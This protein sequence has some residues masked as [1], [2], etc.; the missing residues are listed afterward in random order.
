MARKAARPTPNPE[1][2]APEPHDDAPAAEPAATSP[3]PAEA[4]PESSVRSERITL[5]SKTTSQ[6]MAAHEARFHIFLVDT[7]WNAPVSKAVRH[8]LPLIYQYQRQDTLYILSH[9]QSVQALKNAPYLIGKDPTILV[10]DRFSPHGAKDGNY[11]GFRLNLGLMRNPEQALARLQEFVRFC[12]E[13][14]MAVCLEADVRR[15]MHRE[16]IDG[17]MKI[18]GESLETGLELI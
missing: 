14:R 12:A 8:Q 4:S 3:E 17:A 6:P 10:Y 9:E 15:E 16:G 7:G 11:R 2:P 5:R 18:L 1:P 13:H